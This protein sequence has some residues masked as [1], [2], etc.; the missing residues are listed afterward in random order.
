[1]LPIWYLNAEGRKAVADRA[2]LLRQYLWVRR[3]LRNVVASWGA[4]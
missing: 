2:A 1:M 3:A 4:R